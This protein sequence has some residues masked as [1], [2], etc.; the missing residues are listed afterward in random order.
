MVKGIACKWTEWQE[1]Q[2][3]R[4]SINNVSAR[5]TEQIRAPSGATRRRP[6][7]FTD[8]FIERPGAR[9]GHQPADP[10]AGPA[11]YVPVAGHASIRRP[12]TPSSPSAPPTTARTPPRWPASSRSRWRR[13]SPRRRA[14]ITCPPPAPP[15]SSTITATLRLNY[16]SNRA[17]TEI[18]TQVNSVR[19]QLP[20]QAQQPVLTVQ[21][22]Q[23]IDAMY[24]G[25][26]SD[27]LPTNGVTDY[28]VRVVKPKL[29]SHRG[30]ADRRAARRRGNSRCAP[31]WIRTSM[32]AHNVTAADVYT[33]LAANNYLA[34]VGSTKGQMVTVDLTAGTDLH[35]VD[36]FRQLVVKQQDD[37]IVRLEDVATVALGAEN[38][39][40][41]VAFS[42]K[43][44]VFI[45]IKVA[46]RGER[47]RRR[48]AR[49][50]R[51]ARHR[52][53]AADRH[54]PARSSTTRTMFINTSIREVIKTLVEALLIVT[55]VIFL[56]LGSL[57]AVIDSGGR[58]AAVAGRH[59]LRDAGAGLL[60]QSADAAGAG[61][62]HRPG[63]RRRH[64][65]GRERRPAS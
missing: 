48:Q 15:A 30:R 25:F 28:L 11:R 39:D 33:A 61:A 24:I 22:G 41:N 18:N 12:K 56:F 1:R 34:A 44:S 51:L 9:G 3:R 16:D 38:Y 6:M 53:A 62:G 65:R 64:H 46:P 35:S 47:A 45:G 50:R 14:S 59:L 2:R 55:V 32:A 40:F 52:G 4:V 37:A 20:P 49:A 8:L 10:G 23:T 5:T 54:D 63:G 29:D 43:R 19:N 7:N 13:R 26:F 31:G 27:T 21:I 60:D 36:E 17:L 57:R 42:G 58:H